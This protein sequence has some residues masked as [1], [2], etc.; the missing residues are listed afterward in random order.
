M[1]YTQAELAELFGVG[2]STLYRTIE[3][4]RPKPPEPERSFAHLAN[5]RAWTQ[6][7]PVPPRG[8]VLSKASQ[9]PAR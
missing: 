6:R 1:I 3:Q 9:H 4:I 5:P 2:R 8:L 7:R